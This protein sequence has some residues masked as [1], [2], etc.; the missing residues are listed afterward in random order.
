MFVFYAIEK[1]VLG[2]SERE[3]WTTRYFLPAWHYYWRE[4]E[5]LGLVA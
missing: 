1:F 2:N 3:I 4:V 5:L